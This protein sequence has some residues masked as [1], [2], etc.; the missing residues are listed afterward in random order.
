MATENASREGGI[1]FQ[2]GLHIVVRLTGTVSIL[3]ALATLYMFAVLVVTETFANAGVAAAE[4][5][6][7]VLLTRFAFNVPIWAALGAAFANAAGALPWGDD[8]YSLTY[9][10][11]FGAAVGGAI[12][13]IG[14]A[15]TGGAGWL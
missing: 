12:T 5:P 4:N 7:L 3:V 2:D 13:V 9:G 6:E 8:D 1:G 10:A 15:L 14:F 11:K